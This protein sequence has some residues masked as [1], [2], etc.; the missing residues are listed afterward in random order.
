MHRLLSRFN[1]PRTF[2]STLKTTIKIPLKTRVKTALIG[3]RQNIK[4]DDVLAISSWFL[5]GTTL[6]IVLA[7]TTAT[8]LILLFA[9]AIDVDNKLATFIANNLTKFS[10]LDVSFESA[11]VPVWKDGVLRFKNVNITC[12][13]KTWSEWV[14]ADSKHKGIP[15]SPQ[16]IDLQFTY[17]SLSVE[18]IDVQ[19][20]FMRWIKGQGVI[21]E[22]SV[23]GVRGNID[24]THLIFDNW[25]PQRR[26]PKH[27]DFD[28][29]KFV[30]RDLMVQVNQPNFRPFSISIFNAELP[31][32]RKQW[33]LYDFLKAD[34]VVGMVEGCLFSV[35]KPQ[36]T[37]FPVFTD[38]VDNLWE[39]MV[40]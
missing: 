5:S 1:K 12:N 32:L 40:N 7:T 13:D 11:V 2:F 26:F 15:I 35:Y 10:G 39:K 9:N 29:E 36:R 37:D 22:C 17:Y 14:I 6:F 31:Q 23:S 21:K 38:N 27:G 19:L 18:N 30:V 34:S 28:I 8:S 16:D 24:R 33:I 3:N 4:L 25:V 20:S